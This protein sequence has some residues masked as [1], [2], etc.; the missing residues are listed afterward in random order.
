MKQVEQ[1]LKALG[2]NAFAVEKAAGLPADAVRSILRGGKKSGTTINRAREVCEA[3]GLELYIGPPRVSGPIETVNIG[4]EDYAPIPRLDARASAGP[5][6]EN[7]NAQVIEKLAFRRDWLAR[8]GVDASRAVLVSVKGDSMAPG[9]QDGDLALIDRRRQE[10]RSGNVY[11]LTDTDGSTR[12]KRID[13]LPEGL[14]LRSD[15]PQYPTEFR[16]PGDA[17]RVQI[18]GQVVW[19]GHTW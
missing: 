13:L 10:V 4:N 17:N 12:V 6:T 7:T 14:I 18:I 16:A 5:G 11:A 9:L 3:L 15:A 19:S 8:M 2:T 1:R